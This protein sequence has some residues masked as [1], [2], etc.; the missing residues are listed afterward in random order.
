MTN[1][2]SRPKAW[3]MVSS[4]AWPLMSAGRISLS[5]LPMS[6]TNVNTATVS[7]SEAST[8]RVR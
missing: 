3:K 2:I 4:R 5:T 7:T 1:G 6:S 8:W